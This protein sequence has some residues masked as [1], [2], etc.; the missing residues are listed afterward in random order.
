MAISGT[1]PTDQN[2][3]MPFING[4]GVVTETDPVTEKNA[5]PAGS[6]AM[7]VF[8]TDWVQ[9]YNGQTLSFRSGGKGYQLDAALIAALNA[10]SAPIT[11]V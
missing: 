2:T 5:M 10:A 11:A 3:P 9:A 7:Y 6:A 1:D 8:S 4:G